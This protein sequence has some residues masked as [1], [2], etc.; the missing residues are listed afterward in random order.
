MKSTEVRKKSGICSY[1][2]SLLLE[3]QKY[4]HCRKTSIRV[5]FATFKLLTLLFIVIFVIFPLS[6][7]YSYKLQSSA[8]F[9]NFVHAPS[10]AKYKDPA[11]YGLY[12]SRN[13]Y[14]THDGGITLGVWQVLPENLTYFGNDTKDDR[15]FEESLAN[16]Q[17]VI[18]YHHGNAGTR[19]TP[20]R[21]ELYAVLRK[22]FHVIAFDY[23]SYGDSSS[24]DPSEEK[25]VIDS[26]FIYEWVHNRTKGNIFIWGHSLGTSLA[27]HSL[28]RLQT[29]GLKPAGVFLEA[30]FNNMKEEISEFPLARLFKNLPWFTYTVIEP[31]QENGFLFQT[32]KHICKVNAPVMILHAEDDHVVPFKLGKKV[33]MCIKYGL[34]EY[35]ALLKSDFQLQI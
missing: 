29:K 33:R 5:A 20:H 27:I 19:L 10:D 1:S 31:M 3:G 17:D 11:S 16:G 4:A 24:V 22:H 7:K 25:L 13:F 30:P 35:Y 23:R 8:V 15:Y 12:A 2:Y 14:L 21:V 6:Y 32:D 9:L 18:I 28:A 34:I 26:M